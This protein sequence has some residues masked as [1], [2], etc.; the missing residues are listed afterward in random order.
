MCK[1]GKAVREAIEK[2]RFILITSQEIDQLGE[3]L[4]PVA[5]RRFMQDM[6]PDLRRAIL[7][8]LKL[9]V[10]R[11]VVTGDHGYLFGEEIDPGEKIDP[12]G[13]ETYLLHRRVWIGKGGQQHS[14]YLRLPESR[15]GLS[16]EIELV[17]P[18]GIAAFKSPGGNQVYLHGGISLQEMVIPLLTINARE[19]RGS[20]PPGGMVELS[21]EHEQITNR[22]FT[23]QVTY[24]ADDLFAREKRRVKLVIGAEKSPAGRVVSAVYGYD[25]GSGEVVLEKDKPNALTVVLEKEP[26]PTSVDLQ[27]VDAETGAVLVRKTNLAV[28]LLI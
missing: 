8:L 1:P 12:P 5:A 20:T 24:T 13:G 23:V 4:S 10:S 16:G 17:F 9:G 11:V 6:L 14:A 15:V 7:E 19:K 25:S 22:F 2:A 3:M 18:A 27:V 21:L 28:K 26:P